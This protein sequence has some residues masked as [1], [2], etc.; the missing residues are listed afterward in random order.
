MQPS[1]DPDYCCSKPLHVY[2]RAQAVADGHL[3]DVTDAAREAGFRTP[4]AITAAAWAD[5]VA[6]SEADSRRQTAQDE[7]GRLW[8]VL[9][10]ASFIARRAP[11][12]NPRVL[13]PLYRIPRGGHGVR[14]R[15]TQLCMTIGPG[16]AAAPVITI[17][18]P[19]ED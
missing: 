17:L 4:V 3:I 16:D 13:I 8:D 5:C 18:L 7:A 10:M 19:D 15:R 9:W 14:P 6:W 11:S 2:T 1:P 12:G